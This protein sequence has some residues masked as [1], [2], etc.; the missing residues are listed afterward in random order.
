MTLRPSYWLPTLFSHYQYAQ[1]ATRILYRPV[2]TSSNHLAENLLKKAAHNDGKTDTLIVIVGKQTAGEGRYGRLWVS[3]QG[4]G[5]WFTVAVR[6]GLP[7]SC[8]PPLTALAADLVNLLQSSG[9]KAVLKWPNDVFLGDAKLAGLMAQNKRIGAADWL[10]CGV[11][12]NWLAPDASRFDYPVAGLADVP[13][14]AVDFPAKV[15]LRLA[16]TLQ[17]PKRW[18]RLIAQQSDTHLYANKAVKVSG[19]GFDGLVAVAR[20]I[21]QNGRL[22]V[23]TPQKEY[24]LDGRFRVR[25]L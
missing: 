16:N 22:R 25:L 14:L 23:T 12:V 2:A 17:T 9:V 7:A 3:E 5:L 8:P 11:G 18:G 15:V 19:M 1:T 13:G 21:D 4:A 20:G 10:F 6:G 24:R